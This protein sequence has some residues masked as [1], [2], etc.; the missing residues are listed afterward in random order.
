MSRKR[1]GKRKRMKLVE[2]SDTFNLVGV[3]GSKP[4]IN[5]I[6]WNESF[7]DDT[8]KRV[9]GYLSSRYDMYDADDYDEYDFSSCREKC[10]Y[11]Y[12]DI[13]DRTN[14]R[15]FTDLK[16]FNDFCDRSG[17]Y[18]P[19]TDAGTLKYYDEVHCCLDPNDAMYGDKVL[20]A[21]CSYSS[22]YWYSGQSD[23]NDIY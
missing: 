3:S 5:D 22:L 8:K 15:K 13:K 4:C 17:I 23:I 7:E 12:P 2:R 10:I 9:H 1:R 14:C 18:V 6:M 11:Y 20:M 19:Y 16:S 21:E